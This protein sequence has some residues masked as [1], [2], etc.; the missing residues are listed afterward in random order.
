[1]SDYTVSL[2]AALNCKSAV[3]LIVGSNPLAAARCTLSLAAGATPIVVA[4][5]PVAGEEVHYGLQ[6]HLDA[7][8]KW[9]DRKFEDDDLVTLGRQ[10]IDGVVD[11][12]FVTS[13]SRNVQSEFALSPPLR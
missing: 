11:A 8:V 7:G 4:P 5:R 3:H 10:D 12:V 2:L 1:M 6:K 13:G 9:L